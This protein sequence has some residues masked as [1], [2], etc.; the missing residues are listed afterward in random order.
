[1]LFEP[2]PHFLRPL[3]SLWQTAPFVH[4]GKGAFS[5]TESR[6][7]SWYEPGVIQV[8]QQVSGLV[9]GVNA[10]RDWYATIITSASAPSVQHASFFFED[11]FGN[12]NG[13]L[14]VS[15]R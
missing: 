7:K 11:S 2:L 14:A 10:W 15:I 6:G 12:F 13:M 1:M 9:A 5:I 4:P 3:C 8:E